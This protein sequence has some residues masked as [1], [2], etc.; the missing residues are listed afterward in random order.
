MQRKAAAAELPLPAEYFQFF[1]LPDHLNI[2]LADLEKRYY[3]L[4]RKWHPDRYARKSETERIEAEQNTAL[5]NDAYRTLKDPVHRAEY[6][7]SHHGLA[8]AQQSAPPDLLEEVFELNMALEEIRDGDTSVR[9]QL[10]EARTKFGA[11]QTDIDRTLE[12][13]FEKYDGGPESLGRIRSIL[14]RRNYIRNLL[15]DVGKALQP[16]TSA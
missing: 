8:A 1:D 15:R 13:E 10:E 3:A 14:N 2:D 11:M 6:V 16:G 4:S 12:A 5:L 7:L 9:P